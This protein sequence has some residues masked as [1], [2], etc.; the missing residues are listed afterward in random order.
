M[1]S[2]FGGINAS[3]LLKTEEVSSL[4]QSS[5]KFEIFIIVPLSNFMFSIISPNS[6][7]LLVNDLTMFFKSI[8]IVSSSA[9]ISE[10]TFSASSN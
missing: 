1:F 6:G 7:F 9:S 2:S 10:I 3:K 8:S 5:F 4:N